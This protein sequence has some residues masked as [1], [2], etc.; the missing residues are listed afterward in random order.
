MKTPRK[1]KK[2]TKIVQIT[3][4]TAPMSWLRKMSAKI[5]MAS[6][7]HRK[8]SVNH[9][10]DQ[11]N[12][13]TCH[14]A[15]IENLPSFRREPSRACKSRSSLTRA[16]LSSSTPLGDEGSSPTEVLLLQTRPLRR[17]DGAVVAHSWVGID[18]L[19]AALD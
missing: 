12:C 11:T 1:G 19:D 7:I 2:I 8:N 15:S 16:D 3:F 14:S 4:A 18:A 17:T 10:I 5:E 6:Q 9:N 13:P